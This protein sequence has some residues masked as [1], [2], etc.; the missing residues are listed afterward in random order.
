MPPL[1]ATPLPPLAVNAIQLRTY[2]SPVSVVPSATPRPDPSPVSVIP[3]A[4]RGRT[5]LPRL[6][7]PLCDTAA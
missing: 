2:L 3:S 4:H 6:R 1:H 7:R 5:H